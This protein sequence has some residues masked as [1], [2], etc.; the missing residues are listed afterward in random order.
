VDTAWRPPLGEIALIEPMRGGRDTTCL[1]GVVAELMGEQ[2]R[3]ELDSSTLL[4]DEHDDVV[5][6][7]FRP[8]ALYR[9][10]GTA[11][12]HLGPPAALDIGIKDVER[13]QRRAVP[14]LQCQLPV[15]LSALDGTGS[16]STVHGRTVDI[17]AGGCRVLTQQPY[18]TGSDPTVTIDL[19]DGERVVT[20]ARVLEADQQERRYSYRLVFVDLDPRDVRR[21]G[22]LVEEGLARAVSS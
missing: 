6:T 11:T 3:I 9:M 12:L 16:F 19:P 10:T 8:D 20:L 4:P 14:R 1:T 2:L 5:V 7:V 18:D 22:A 13:V 17:G 21:V 15:E